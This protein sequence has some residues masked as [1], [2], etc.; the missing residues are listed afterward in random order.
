M[1]I[2]A[3]AKI[4][5]TRLKFFESYG[6]FF[7][8]LILRVST[9]LFA[10]ALLS[11]R[12][13]HRTKDNRKLFDLDERTRLDPPREENMAAKAEARPETSDAEGDLVWSKKNVDV[14]TV[15]SSSDEII[16]TFDCDSKSTERSHHSYLNMSTLPT[17]PV[18]YRLLLKCFL[19]K[20]DGRM[21]SQLGKMLGKHKGKEPK[22]CLIL[23][24]KYDA[25]NPLNRV[26]VSRVTEEHFDDY[27]KLTTLYLSI[28]YPQ[29]VDEAATLCSNH[30]GNEGELFKKL[31]S[32]FHAINPLTM[33]RPEK[34][35][36]R[37]VDYKSILTAFLLEHDP[38]QAME[39]EEILNK[40]AGKEAILFSVFAAQYDTSNALNAVFQERL[41]SAQPKE[42][43]SLLKLYLSV[44]HPSILADAK[45]MLEHCKGA[46][47][48]LFSRLSTKFRACNPLDICGE[49]GKGPLNT[50]EEVMLIQEDGCV[51][52]VQ[53]KQG[54]SPVI[55]PKAMPKKNFSQSPAVT[56]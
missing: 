41:A 23:A 12:K 13:D 49:L 27:V 10:M 34:Q 50:I 53:R 38:E 56:P 21:I 5:K 31:S 44:F 51:S 35:Y 46:K 15:D 42:H 55:T 28:F 48:E 6:T 9:R 3:L 20:H 47:D 37:P 24:R 26:F 40:C 36:S 16:E 8:E 11:L 29:D 54:R 45:S 4:W 18:D 43:L 30:A 1:S 17:K 25:S 32:N 22:L 33:D 7:W 39:A 14:T 2:S 19:K 52:P